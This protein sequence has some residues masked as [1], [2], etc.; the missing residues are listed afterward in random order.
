VRRRKTLG[1][2]VAVA[3]VG[4]LF[5]CS[6]AA[7]PRIAVYV[8]PAPPPKDDGNA[9]K[10]G[11]GGD[12]HAAALEQLKTAPLGWRV[13]KQRSLRIDLPDA[14][15]WTRVKFWGV[16][17]LVGFRYGKD[18]H[19][20][21]AAFITHVDDNAVRGA[22]P[23]SFEKLAQ[24]VLDSFEVE[25]ERLPPKA[26]N[27]RSGVVDILSVDAKTATII[28][29][30]SYAAAFAAYPAWPGACLIVGVAVP[31]RDDLERA[32]AV[33]DRFAESVL[34]TVDVRAKEEPTERY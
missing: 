27:W 28:D 15:H 14:A 4:G 8:A 12:R 18:H 31:A 11:E 1:T 30:D 7:P 17:S 3:A 21:V 25:L 23:A 5:G 33:R 6:S 34:P 24:P 13:D 19:A 22:C 16:P 9:A 2:V 29:H 26:E 10:G 20:I 32:R